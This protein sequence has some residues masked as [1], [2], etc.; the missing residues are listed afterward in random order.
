MFS[1]C[2][3]PRVLPV[4]ISYAQVD[5]LTLT[6]EQEGW[7]SVFHSALE[8]KLKQLLGTK[9]R[10]AW[11]DV[12]IDG[13]HDF[14]KEIEDSILGAELFVSVI[15]PTYV[16]D[17]PW[18]LWEI[19]RFI[20][21]A[22]E[23]RGLMVGNRSRII[24]I[25]KTPVPEREQPEPIRKLLGYRFFELRPNGDFD[26]FSHEKG[27]PRYY[28]FWARF[29]DVAKVI[30][31]IVEELQ[32]S[33]G[34]TQTAPARRSGAPTVFLSEPASDLQSERDRIRRNLEARG[35][36]VL[37][38]QYL[39]LRPMEGNLRSV[40]E[41][42]LSECALCI[43]LIGPTQNAVPEGESVT[44]DRI[45][46]ELIEAWQ[47]G[48]P[49][50]RRLIW[51][52]EG[53]APVGPAQEELVE[54][55]NDRGAGIPGT[56]VLEV[57]FEDFL[58][59]VSDTLAEFHEGERSVASEDAHERNH[60][61]LVFD[62]DDSESAREVGAFLGERGFEVLT[63][64]VGLEDARSDVARAVHLAHLELADGVLIY[65]DR[66]PPTWLDTKVSDLRRLPGYG[67][68][69]SSPSVVLLGGEATPFKERFQSSDAEVL[70]PL[71]RFEPSVLEAFLDRIR[72][73]VFE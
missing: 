4:F 60:V 33:A 3:G 13:A 43:Q 27:H 1:R 46:N 7:V 68:G 50:A 39:P 12:A 32:D 66:G 24:K 9:A 5:N 48:N 64:V 72:T 47:E 61:Y 23:R 30:A 36:T 71:L 45:Q 73:R 41:D 19:E 70:G 49:V 15:S 21:A 40:V 11:R 14:S 17:S 63:P 29:T 22:D 6:P 53:S 25:L 37:P 35:C 42:A 34:A 56:E 16:R 44:L 26:E 57:H 20:E 69:T 54:E 62:E 58:T 8:I 2:L 67:H 28:D 51:L 38:S 55:L 59:H 18:C 31:R 52:P 10:V 65:Y